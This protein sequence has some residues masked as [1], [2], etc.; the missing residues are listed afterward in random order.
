VLTVKILTKET[1]FIKERISQI[2]SMF[3][4]SSHNQNFL[5]GKI[6]LQ[7]KSFTGIGYLT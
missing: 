5:T 3:V 1:G 4:D 7:G 2:E 6:F